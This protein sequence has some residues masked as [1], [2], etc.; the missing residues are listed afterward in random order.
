MYKRRKK[1]GLQNI[2]N[3]ELFHHK[4]YTRLIM[5]ID[6]ALKELLR[7]EADKMDLTLT[8]LVLNLITNFI[9]EKRKWLYG[10]YGVFRIGRK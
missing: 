10:V 8:N 1:T 2:N 5:N 7:V 6:P 3:P 4:G 9:Q